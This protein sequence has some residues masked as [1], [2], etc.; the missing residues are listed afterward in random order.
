[1][2]ETKSARNRRWD[3]ADE[4]EKAR[5]LEDV[6]RQEKIK[7][8]ESTRPPPEP[9]VIEMLMDDVYETKNLKELT[10]ADYGK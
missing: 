6:A 9:G 3:Q 1:L 8:G 5:A 10:L 2:Y 7:K 4:D